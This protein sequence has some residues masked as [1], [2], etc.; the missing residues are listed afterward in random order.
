MILART[1]YSGI[2]QGG[3]SGEHA[4]KLRAG[5]AVSLVKKDG[6]RGYI[7]C[8]KDNYFRPILS[9]V[10]ETQRAASLSI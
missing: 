6:D 4:Y 1:S 2:A 9:P 5:G 3:K 7:R 10:V 8:I